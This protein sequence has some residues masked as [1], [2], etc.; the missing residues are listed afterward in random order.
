M[1]L[2]RLTPLPDGTRAFLLALVVAYNSASAPPPPVGATEPAF[3]AATDVSLF[4]DDFEAYNTRADLT[5]GTKAK[6]WLLRERE[7]GTVSLIH[8]PGGDYAGGSQFVRFDYTAPGEYAN[9]IYTI[10]H[11]NALLATATTVVLTYGY[12]NTGTFYSGK[13]LIIRDLRGAN[14]FVFVGASYFTTPQSLQNCWYSPIYP[15]DALYSYVQHRGMVPTL[16]RDGL[17]ADG[18][19]RPHFLGGNVGYP[20]AQFGQRGTQVGPKN[21]GN[22]HRFTYRFTKE[23]AGGG[24]GR[25]EGWFDGV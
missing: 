4:Y 23:S 13:E 17:E 24:T 11:R 5:T 16:S 12:R 15:Y 21:D 9:E 25:L 1:V 2:D 3:N 18:V 19:P 14:R 20:A 10:K 6:Y 7:S 8:S 22:W